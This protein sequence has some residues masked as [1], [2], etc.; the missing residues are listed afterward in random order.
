MRRL[1]P[2]FP[3]VAFQLGFS[4]IP[5]NHE[6]TEK[7]YLREASRRT[8]FWDPFLAFFSEKVPFFPRRP[9][10]GPAS[11]FSSYQRRLR[12][13]PARRVN[14][15]TYVTKFGI[16]FWHFF[17][18]KFRFSLEGLVKV[19]HLVLARTTG[20]FAQPC[21]AGQSSKQNVMQFYHESTVSAPVRRFRSR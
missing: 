21:P 7:S 20:D 19:R 17:L 15:V 3:L 10:E 1:H 11:R 8:P 9:G 14:L 12:R 2:L 18:K 13:N 6:K 5:E 16:L 4:G